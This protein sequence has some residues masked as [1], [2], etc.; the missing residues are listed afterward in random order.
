MKSIWKGSIT[1]GLVN[2]PI[3]LFSASQSSSLDFDMLDSKDGSRIRYKRV[4]ETSGK[5]VDWK[6]IA[7]G[8]LYNDK[9][10]ILSDKDFELASPKKTK[11]IEIENFVSIE[12]IPLIYFDSPYYIEPDKA[13]AKA[14][15]LLLK[16][17]IKSKRAG[18]A[19][20]VLRTV[21]Q[22]SVIIPYKNVLILQKIRFAEEIK[23]PSEIN[24]P[25]STV[26]A[27]EL[28]MAINLI[29]Q[30]AGTFDISKYKNEY[31]ADLLKLIKKKASGKKLP[32][33]K[34]KVI[35][36]ADTSLLDQLKASLKPH[37]KASLI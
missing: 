4:N 5:E 17:L 26:N 28:T 10:V 15:N 7:K 19:R 35:H 14:Y 21:E 29:D 34:L 24:I 1:F 23:S 6:K 32:E 36:R 9:Y 8:Y 20:V 22:L 11:T 37:S 33:A 18:L 12:E 3:R 25:K 16:A 2:V 13:G 30:Y 27:K 31:S